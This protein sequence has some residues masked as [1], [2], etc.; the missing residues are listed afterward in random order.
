MKVRHK[1]R[2]YQVERFEVLDPRDRETVRHQVT[3]IVSPTGRNVRIELDGKLL[4]P[5]GSEP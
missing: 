3:F 4:V 1:G 2:D 5:E